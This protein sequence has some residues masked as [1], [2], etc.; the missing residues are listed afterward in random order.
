MKQV[1][2]FCFAIFFA[3][4]VW[5]AQVDI[6]GIRAELAALESQSRQLQAGIDGLRSRLEE[7]ETSESTP[8]TGATFTP[9]DPDEDVVRWRDLSAGNSRLSIYGFARVDVIRD[10]GRSDNTQK[11]IFVRSASA[12]GGSE[13][14]LHPRLSRIGLNFSPLES[15]SPGESSVS[16]KLEVDFQNGGRESRPALRIRHAFLEWKAG[17]ASI[18]AGQTW[19]IISPLFPTANSDTLMWNVG[20]LGDR[21][22]QIRFSLSPEV[23][24]GAVELTGGLLLGGAVSPTDFDQDGFRDSESSGRPNLQARAGYRSDRVSVGVWGHQGW[25]R[26]NR[27]IPTMFRSHALGGDFDVRVTTRARWRGEAWVGSNLRDV[28]GGAGQG[29]NGARLNAIRSRG[30][31]SELSFQTTSRNTVAA[32][33][34]VDDPTNRDIDTGGIELNRSVYLA[35][36][37]DL[38]RGL[39]LGFDYIY[40]KTRFRN[41]AAGKNHRTNLFLIYR[42]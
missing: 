24:N 2:F 9:K 35:D 33:Y 6:Q 42:Y 34:T 37:F 11:P 16:G 41:Q 19:D 32:G 38:G 20:N 22:P 5:S 21:K 4:P 3:G 23:G 28:R 18:L 40:W 31:W 13:F 26:V 10:S 1:G 36:R 27:D 8:P 7:L 15:S 17:G 39:Q 14:T 29:I 25:E 30:G 12:S